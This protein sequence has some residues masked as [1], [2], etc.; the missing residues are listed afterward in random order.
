MSPGVGEAPAV[1]QCKR[2]IFCSFA[3]VAADALERR[4][5][6]IISPWG[7]SNQAYHSWQVFR[8]AQCFP[9]R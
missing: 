1:H 4:N 2:V 7:G 6:A 9:Q 5:A 3:F 8:T